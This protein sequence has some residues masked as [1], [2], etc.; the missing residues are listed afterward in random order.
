MNKQKI[1]FAVVVKDGKAVKVGR[2]YAEHPPIRYDGRKLK[3]FDDSVLR[4]EALRI[5]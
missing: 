2:S 1:I 5:G 4:K 3:W